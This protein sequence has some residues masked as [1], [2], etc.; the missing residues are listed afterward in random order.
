VQD[1]CLLG[2]N[3]TNLVTSQYAL[4]FRRINKGAPTLPPDHIALGKEGHESTFGGSQRVSS[5][6]HQ[7]L[8]LQ[9]GVRMASEP[10]QTATVQW[11]LGKP[12]D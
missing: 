1:I 2:N 9:A 3:V 4:A 8:P 5:M 6:T 12:L 10:A 7:T 11:H